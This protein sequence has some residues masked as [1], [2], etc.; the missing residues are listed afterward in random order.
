MIHS[1]PDPARGGP[2]KFYGLDHLRAAA[3]LMVLGFHYCVFFGHPGW[4]ENFRAFGWTGVDLFFVLSGF[5]ISSQ[6]FTQ[7]NKGN[8]LNVREF[9]IK[10]IYRILPI[11]FFMVALYFF[12]PYFREK[13]ALPP[14]W[15]F[16][17][18]TQ[19]FR[20]NNAEFGTFSHAWSLC[21]E[22]HFYL[23]LPLLLLALQ[24]TKFLKSS[25]WILIGLFAGGLALRIFL[26]KY[27]YPHAGEY[28]Y[29]IANWTENIYYPTYNRLDGL[30]VGVSVA[31]FYKF[32]QASWEKWSRLGN[33]SILIG[34][35]IL[36][37]AY[38][39]ASD[40]ETFSTTVF[41]FPLIAIGY[42][43]LVMG[44]ISPSSFL[45]QWRS[46]TTTLVAALSY[47]AYLSHKGIIHITQ[48]LLS[49][50]GLDKNS[51]VTMA[52]CAVTCLLAAWILHLAIEKPFMRL[53]DRVLGKKRAPVVRMDV[54][55]LE[56]GS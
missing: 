37:G 40:M 18:F 14:V 55:P 30:V 41:G 43:F 34:L 51:S 31:A 20:L 44:A 45:Y 16:L 39:F 12:V 19:N 56:Q 15:K 25:Y 36:T 52:V 53:R 3:I 50:A 13:E 9:F 17:T 6:L 32:R 8:P 1:E 38:F 46:K 22:E 24:G 48:Q 47:A 4:A 11:Y 10:R 5:L 7:I 26:W 2:Q 27:Y 33:L 35:L 42:G 29:P 49:M 54:V 23:L 28:S 21:V